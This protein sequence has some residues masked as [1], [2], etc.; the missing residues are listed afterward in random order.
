[1]QVTMIHITGG[2]RADFCERFARVDTAFGSRTRK[3]LLRFAMRSSGTRR[4]ARLDWHA[5]WK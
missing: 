1:M 5:I 2:E 4:S 3:G